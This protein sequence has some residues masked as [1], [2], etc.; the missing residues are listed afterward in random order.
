MNINSLVNLATAGMKRSTLLIFIALAMMASITHDE[1]A[2][3]VPRMDDHMMLFNYL[4]ADGSGARIDGVA[5][6][7]KHH[8]KKGGRIPFITP[9]MRYLQAAV[10]GY[11]FDYYIVF[12]LVIHMLN[13]F[14]LA[15]LCIQVLKL[16][17]W[18]SFLLATFYL[19]GASYDSVFNSLTLWIGS[20]YVYLSTLLLV[21][22]L[23]FSVK[24]KRP[25]IVWTVTLLY[26]LFAASQLGM[27]VMM[28]VTLL[29]YLSVHHNFNNLRPM[30]VML[31]FSLIPVVVYVISPEVTYAGTRMSTDPYKVLNN[32]SAFMERIFSDAWLYIYPFLL[33]IVYS[34]IYA[35]SHRERLMLLAGIGLV[36]L[37]PLL[38]SLSVKNRGESYFMYPSFLGLTLIAAVSL[39]VNSHNP[40]V[41]RTR[42]SLLI[43]VSLLAYSYNSYVQNERFVKHTQRI[44]DLYNAFIERYKYSINEVE[45]KGIHNSLVI[46]VDGRLNDKYNKL[47]LGNYNLFINYLAKDSDN[48]YLLARDYA[49]V[50]NEPRYDILFSHYKRTERRLLSANSI[51]Y[52]DLL[53]TRVINEI[54]ELGKN[55]V[56]LRRAITFILTDD[57]VKQVSP[58]DLLIENKVGLT[59]SVTTYFNSRYE[60]MYLVMNGK[61]T[62]YTHTADS[63]K[64]LLIRY[65][66]K[67]AATLKIESD[68]TMRELRCNRKPDAV[69]FPTDIG[70]E[71]YSISAISPQANNAGLSLQASYVANSINQD[72]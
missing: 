4:N 62:L 69:I 64:S 10:F 52:D 53:T 54:S 42:I 8:E 11:H 18:S 46:L 9:P 67:K 36:V 48:I 61:L 29:L 5:D 63:D 59:G 39:K 57:G 19:V 16:T 66:C 6:E 45:R 40:K 38:Y 12:T 58:A 70:E 43:L 47:N 68:D 35:R 25:R 20:H 30:I 51:A 17:R 21:F 55:K 7:F 26:S 37:L 13:S 56:D 65:A 71:K 33:M 14:L 72:R 50:G 34:T 60:N 2:G 28:P 1:I 27:V 24:E 41:W 22:I 44:S 3:Y 31:G 32:L 49:I 15:L 23:A